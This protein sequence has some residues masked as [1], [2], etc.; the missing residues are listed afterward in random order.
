LPGVGESQERDGEYAALYASQLP[1]LDAL[2]WLIKA[3]DRAYTVD[4]QFYHRVVAPHIRQ[5]MPCLFVA[6]Q[7]DRM[8][9]VREWDE[10]RHQPGQVQAENL[11][12]RRAHVAEQFGIP[13]QSVVVIS[14]MKNYQLD[15]LVDQLVQALPDEKRI[16]T[17]K[18]VQR[19]HRSPA[20]LQAGRDSL[21]TIVSRTLSGTM[22]GIGI[23]SR[24]GKVGAVVGAIVG[25]I[26]GFLDLW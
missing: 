5:G 11:R 21:T 16:G 15:T 2:L 20:S 18:S 7:A 12:K 26:G 13:L 25:A 4:E 10:L 17:L 1:Q 3:D 24:S 8:N 6:S 23:G 22:K 19:M 9:P 14:A